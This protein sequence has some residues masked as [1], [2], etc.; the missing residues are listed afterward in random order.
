MKRARLGP[1][2]DALMALGAMRTSWPAEASGPPRHPRWRLVRRVAA[3]VVATNADK[4]LLVASDFPK[5]WGIAS[6]F[7]PLGGAFGYTLS[8][9]ARLEMADRRA[10]CLETGV[11]SYP[12]VMALVGLSWTGCT[13]IQVRAFVIIATFWYL[14]ST[15][16]MVPFIQLVT[17]EDSCLLR[18]FRRPSTLNPKLPAVQSTEEGAAPAKAGEGAARRQAGLKEVLKQSKYDGLDNCYALFARAA[19]L[20]PN[21]YCFGWRTTLASGNAGAFV[22]MTYRE[23]HEQ[24]LQ[25]ASGVA[26][27]GLPPKG[28]FGMYS[29]N[30][31]RFQIATLGM[32]SQGHTCVPVYD[33]LGED[34]IQYEAN[35]ADM[36]IMFVEVRG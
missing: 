35:H 10:V 20:Y 5:L 33:T 29:A 32:M 2:H 15:A 27:L 9:L 26:R 36:P 17:V 7:Q 25:L 19:R 8:T 34:I 3:F 22:W 12:L 13:K 24:V 6:F 14:I 11:Q 18:C 28:T 31:A 4:E 23:T 30:C 1:P 21:N 16:W